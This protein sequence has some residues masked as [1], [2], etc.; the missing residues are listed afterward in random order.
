MVTCIAKK[1]V[2]G[3]SS[4]ASRSSR[5]RPEPVASR[6]T[7]RSV[8]T[9]RVL[10]ATVA[11]LAG[12]AALPSNAAEPPHFELRSRQ[13]EYAGPGR[14]LPEP[15]QFEEVGLG[16]FG[17]Q[18]DDDLWRAAQMAIEDANRDGGYH[19]RPFRLVPGW[20]ADPWGTGVTQVTRMIYRD[21]VWG[22]VGGPDGPST[23]LAE[24]VVAKAR[25]VLLSPGSTDKSVN[26]ANV[27]WMFSCLP[28]DHL[29][30]PPLV[31]RLVETV[32]DQPFIVLSANDHDSRH[33]AREL[34]RC[35]ALHKIVPQFKYVI[36]PDAADWSDLL[37]KSLAGNPCAVVM[38]ANALHS[39][40]VVR[41]LQDRGY[42]GA[43]FGGPAVGR[44]AFH[45][46]AGA[47]ADGVVYPLLLEEDE[48]EFAKRFRQRFGYT[49]DYAATCSYDAVNMLV[50]AVRHSGLNR[51]K[52]GDAVRNLSPYRGATGTIQ[53]DPLGCN[54][55]SVSLGTI[56]A[57][58]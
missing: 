20:S 54:R 12:L 34:D 10:C 45:E 27:P 4:P 17:P 15:E 8:L 47:A 39:A 46:A 38:C 57:R 37:D 43:V 53:W 48:H 13:T 55:R 1:S 28:G 7:R 35:F 29:L 41:Q 9:T 56:K 2:G 36:N 22:I 40:K 24:Q 51:A 5:P 16:Y 25:L 58:H 21:H 42:Q 52:I 14:E 44:R 6:R 30:A 3:W 19:G 31:Q 18:E 33:F 49:A 32:G 11:V 50:A 23:H 26:L